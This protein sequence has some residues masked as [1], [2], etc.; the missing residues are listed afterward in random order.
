MILRDMNYDDTIDI[1][2]LVVGSNSAFTVKD[3]ERFD[4]YTD[5]R[6]T[7]VITNI[8]DHYDNTTGKFVCEYPGIY[9]FTSFMQESP[10][11]N[12]KKNYNTIMSFRTSA[13]LIIQLYKGDIVQIADCGYRKYMYGGTFSGVLLKAV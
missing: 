9:L 10:Y 5:I 4:P 13:T 11:C 6:F 8:G 3:A 7:S 2:F 1:P 12:F